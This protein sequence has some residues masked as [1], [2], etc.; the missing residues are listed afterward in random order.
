MLYFRRRHVGGVM[1]V[2]QIMCFL[3]NLFFR[4]IFFSFSRQPKL[5]GTRSL[6]CISK[7]TLHAIVH[8]Q[9]CCVN[10][11]VIHVK[12][13]SFF[14]MSAIYRFGFSLFFFNKIQQVWKNMKL[15]E[16]EPL[17]NILSFPLSSIVTM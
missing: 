5:K 17:P 15:Q 13:A 4:S 8:A 9:T 14:K 16:L 11:D 7:S 2:N 6:Q 10:H 1:T 12:S 3:S